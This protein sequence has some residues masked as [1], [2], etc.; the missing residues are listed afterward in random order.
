M[1]LLSLQSLA[2]HL[3]RVRGHPFLISG[4]KVRSTTLYS[5][6]GLL[7]SSGFSVPARTRLVPH[8]HSCSRRSLPTWSCWRTSSVVVH[9]DVAEADEVKMSTRCFYKME[10]ETQLI[11]ISS[12]A[13]YF[14]YQISHDII[15]HIQGVF[16]SPVVEW[17]VCTSHVFILCCANN[18]PEV[19]KAVSLSQQEHKTKKNLLI[20]FSFESF[21]VVCVLLMQHFFETHNKNSK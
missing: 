7:S 19:S 20:L 9:L 18:Q 10:S 6:Q 8:R 3:E 15:V 16:Y 17:S 2:S 12:L 11:I 21:P 5:K 1:L 13:A 4:D 14:F